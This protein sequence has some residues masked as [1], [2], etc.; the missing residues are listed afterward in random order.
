MSMREFDPKF[1]EVR[2]VFGFLLAGVAPRPI[3]LVST[4]SED[5]CVNLAP[6]S[7]FNAF[8]A[9]P[10]IIAFSP[11]R[12]LRDSS[13]KDTYNN[14]S[15]TKECVIQAVTYEIAQQVNLA[16][17]D[18]ES[19]VNEFE[20]SGLTAVDSVIVK[21]PRVAESPFQMECRLN[22]M[23]TLGE[24][25]ASGNL[26]ICEVLRFHI[27][28][29]ILDG[30]TIDLNKL[31]LVARMGGARYCRASGDSVF[32]IAKPTGGE[33]IG[34]DGLP[35]YVRLSKA[36]SAGDIALLAGASVIP[37]V[38]EAREF[39]EKEEPL[40]AAS[41][42]VYRQYIAEK[43]H[44]VLLRIARAEQTVEAFEAAAKQA[45]A[46]TEINSSATEELVTFAWNALVYAQTL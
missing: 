9:N 2:D 30:E 16:S 36:L 41:V 13:V 33:E 28:E 25:G 6:F 19:S 26:A 1:T 21:P 31:D 38:S 22:Q 44:V 11:S 17:A 29:T 12:R 39:V 35:D 45:L 24:G 46:T 15:A 5:G 32:E 18:Y 10:P 4:V 37:S 8:S 14:I 42:N 40:S 3:A 20:K 34:Y 27:D 43:D 23:V 7:F